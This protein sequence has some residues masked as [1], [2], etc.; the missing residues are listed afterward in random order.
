MEILS[1]LGVV[2]SDGKIGRSTGHG[3]C[4]PQAT[5]ISETINQK[6]IQLIRP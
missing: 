3:S 1:K 4:G 2:K 6:P 5:E